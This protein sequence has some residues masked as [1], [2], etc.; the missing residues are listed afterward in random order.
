VSSAEH[1]AVDGVNAYWTDQ[2]S[3][4]RTPKGGGTITPM[5]PA[6]RFSYGVAVDAT[7]V[8]WTNFTKTGGVRAAP[9]TGGAA[10]DV[11]LSLDT[12]TALALFGTDCF[13]AVNA[14]GTIVRV[15]K[16]GGA[17][18]TL[19]AAQPKPYNIA[20]DASGVYWT[21]QGDESVRKLGTGSTTPVV[22]ATNTANARFIATDA[23]AV[24][25]TTT[26]SV[27]RLAK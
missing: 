21:N 14:A 3:V 13:V 2:V 5:A 16:A 26:T 7:D 24:Y 18:T 15:P 4:Y 8:Y 1:L 17:T 23:T 27:M 19:A 10:R 6:E 12:P 11:A 22:I 25:W 9:V 20:V